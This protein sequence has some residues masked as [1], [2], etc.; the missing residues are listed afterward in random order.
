MFLHTQRGKE[1]GAEARTSIVPVTE[2][3]EDFL[4][5]ART[6][7]QMPSLS[8]VPWGHVAIIKLSEQ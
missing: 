8:T 5:A 7:S 4:L 1:E 6:P 2:A 3:T